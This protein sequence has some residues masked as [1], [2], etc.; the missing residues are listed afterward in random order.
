MK[1]IINLKCLKLIRSCD[2]IR[3]LALL[4]LALT[5]SACNGKAP[6]QPE[7][8][9]SAPAAPPISVEQ[10]VERNRA[11]EKAT[12]SLIKSRARIQESGSETREIRMTVYRKWEADGSQ[13]MLVEFNTPEEKDR[14]GLISISPQGEVEGT[15]YAQS[16]DSFVTSKDP[17]GE[18]GLFGMSLQELADGQ[19]EKYDFKFVKE[20][21]VGTTPAYRLDGKLKPGAASK[22]PRMVVLMSKDNFTTLAIEFYDAQDTIA[23]KITMD[24]VEQIQG[25]WARMKWT[26]DNIARKKNI[27]FETESAKYDQN[28]NESIFTRDNLKKL[29]SR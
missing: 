14:A 28:L 26:V 23:R 25:H 9:S 15:R 12:S 2:S 22:F 13:K 20:E 4:A 27:V 18:D 10:M 16:N 1:I 29:A 6:I 19:P 7:N 5:L 17:A 3:P 24:K 8:T 21:T 11:T